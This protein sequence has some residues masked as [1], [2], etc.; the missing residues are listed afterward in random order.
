MRG[1][2][3]ERGLAVSESD[4]A[5]RHATSTAPARASQPTQSRTAT[6]GC[7]LHAFAVQCAATG[8]QHPHLRSLQQD[9]K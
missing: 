6:C 2:L 4:T 8:R 7:T 5:G 1:R 3:G 9:L